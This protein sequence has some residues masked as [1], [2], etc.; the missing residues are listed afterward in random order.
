MGG[1]SPCQSVTLRTVPASVVPL[2]MEELRE[3]LVCGRFKAIPEPPW[4]GGASGREELRRERDQE[5]LLQAALKLQDLSALVNQ[6]RCK[7][8]AT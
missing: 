6:G 1:N 5:A 4:G 8:T 2:D 7:S 3:S